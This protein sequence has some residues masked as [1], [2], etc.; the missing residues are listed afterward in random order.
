MTT[1]S[2][3]PT[4]K[5]RQDQIPAVLLP[6]FARLSKEIETPTENWPTVRCWSDKHLR[7]LIKSILDDMPSLSVSAKAVVQRLQEA[8][9]ARLIETTPLCA[10]RSTIP[11]SDMEFYVLGLGVGQPADVD[12]FELLQAFQPT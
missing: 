3:F 4:H 10:N 8:G 12:P 11:R 7:K 1:S 5:R 9:L 6:L 2:L